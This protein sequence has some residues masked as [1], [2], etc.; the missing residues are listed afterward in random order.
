[1]FI[2]FVSR[3]FILLVCLLTGDGE[4]LHLFGRLGQVFW[5][6]S[7]DLLGFLKIR[8]RLD[9]RRTGL[10]TWRVG[11]LKSRGRPAGWREH[12]WAVCRGLTPVGGHL[13]PVDAD[14]SAV[15]M[16]LTAVGAGLAKV[17]TASTIVETARTDVGTART[18]VDFA[19][20]VADARQLVVAQHFFHF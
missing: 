7:A 12:L 15:G 5:G 9:G 19:P 20:V 13:S 1:M 8:A 11:L 18:A 6:K 10:T 17:D 16:D 2:W 14:L 4:N 3:I